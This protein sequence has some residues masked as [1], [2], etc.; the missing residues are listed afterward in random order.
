MTK[1]ELRTNFLRGAI[2]TEVAA[3]LETAFDED[4]AVGGRFDAIGF[5]QFCPENE[6]KDVREAWR[7]YEAYRYLLEQVS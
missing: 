4:D 1:Q 6:H 7:A 5:G 3:I 2:S